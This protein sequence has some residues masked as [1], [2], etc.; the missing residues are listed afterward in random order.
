MTEPEESD[1]VNRL[2]RAIARRD[3]RIARQERLIA[4]LSKPRPRRRPSAR[5]STRRRPKK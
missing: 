4:R 5:R 1:L 2:R 3:Q